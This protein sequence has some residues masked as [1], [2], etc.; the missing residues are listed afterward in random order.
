MKLPAFCIDR[1]VFTSM[2]SLMLI[3]IGVLGFLRLDVRATPHVFR[4]VLFVKTQYPGA[5]AKLVEQEITHK[6]EVKL[7]GVPGLDR[8]KSFSSPGK[9]FIKLYFKSISQQDFVSIQSQVMAA[10]TGTR[11]P[12]AVKMPRMFTNSGRS[13][14]MII[15]F[16]DPNKTPAQT[17]S[18]L[19]QYLLNQFQQIPGIGEVDVWGSPQGLRIALNPEKMAALGVT[20]QD[21]QT[22]LEN[23]NVSVPVGS[24]FNQSQTLPVNSTM[25]LANVAQFNRLV[26]TK[27]GS[28]L[29][30]LSQ[31]A[32][33]FVGE[34]NWQGFQLT[35]DG[36]RAVALNLQVAANGNP[37]EVTSAAKKLLAKIR[38]TLPPGMKAIVSLN[39]GRYLKQSVVE[40]YHTIIEALILVILITFL[41]LGYWRAALIP[42]VT[43]PVCIISAFAIIFMLGYT[44][45][46]MTLLALVLAVGLVVDD[47]IVVLENSSRH[48]QK[49]EPPIQAAKVASKEISFAV[50]GM[51][52]TLI[53]VYL[54]VAFMTGTSAK[55]FQEFSFTLAGAVL[56]S[57]FV[58][59][60]L[61]PMMC[62]NFLNRTKESRYEVFVTGFFE[63][64]RNGYRRLLTR[65]FNLRWLVLLIFLAMLVLGVYL[66]EELPSSF[67]PHEDFG[68][69]G[70]SVTAP[71][72]ASMAYTAKYNNEVI[73]KALKMPQIKHSLSFADGPANNVFNVLTLT[74]WNKR[75]LT[76]A[77]MVAAINKKVRNIP[78]V[79]AGVFPMNF[80]FGGGNN[81]KSGM[82]F[83]VRSFASYA[84]INVRVKQLLS[85]LSKYPGARNVMLDTQFNSQQYDL[86]INRSLVNELDIPITNVTQTLATMLGGQ[87][88]ETQYQVGGYS[89]PIVLQLPKKALRDFSFLKKIYVRNASGQMISIARLV[90]VKPVL[91][92]TQRMHSNQMRGI[93]VNLNI[94]KGYTVGQVVKEVNALSK[95][96]LPAG[97]SVVYNGAARRMQ[98]SN[99]RMTWIFSLGLL[100]IYFVLASLFESVIDPFVILLTVPV[101]IVG[102]LFA[103][104]LLHGSINLYTGIGLVTLIGLVSKHGVLIVQFANERVQQGLAV[105]DAVV[106]AA[107]TRLRPILMTTATMSLGA[108]P[109]ALATGPGSVSRSQI[110]WVIVAGLLIGTIFSLLIVPVAYSFLAKFKKVTIVNPVEKTG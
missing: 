45:N 70:I 22:A 107:A 35:A 24:I 57:G 75:K 27:R 108:L 84:E 74:S 98:E 76:T 4:P 109:L 62:G 18:Y 103:L 96:I 102:A 47:A 52:I 8:M 34:E 36:H 51:T 53:A 60:T 83:T 91:S 95:E 64:L 46:T 97:D 63:K 61:S 80:G 20:T 85:A 28:Q 3:V 104:K 68:A 29:V 65:L 42:I 54:P 55:Y 105:S 12:P 38:P 9:S 73:Q 71:N 21:I 5:S 44:I 82:N 17:A 6:L 48:L 72:S 56:I 58:A 50:I 67:M 26:I 32:K 13:Q 100:F 94:A 39:F 15:S 16:S 30:R 79:L 37:I 110:G 14:V 10:V 1:P 2:L 59:L 81:Q 43:I 19:N 11:L 106:D 77:D 88:L 93:Q 87:Q 49:G 25:N 92:L 69:V 78:Q 7:A 99:Q 90:T 31:V 23:N 89:Y 41:F 33:V 101:C 66:F 40:V 86:E